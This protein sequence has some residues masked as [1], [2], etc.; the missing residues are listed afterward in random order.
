MKPN[1]IFKESK[2]NDE[3]NKNKTQSNLIHDE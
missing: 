1:Q 2:K 3:P